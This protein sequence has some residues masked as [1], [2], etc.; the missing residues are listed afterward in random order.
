MAKHCAKHDITVPDGGECWNCEEQELIASG[1]RE[2]AYMDP[3]FLHKR[4]GAP[5]Q[6]SAMNAA[7]NKL[8][9]LTPEQLANLIALANA[10]PSAPDKTRPIA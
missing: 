1:G 8:S 6:Q 4:G 10:G 2:A 9:S 5:I 7:L 3:A